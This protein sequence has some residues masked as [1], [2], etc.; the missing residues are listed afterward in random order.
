MQRDL[1]NI[2][3]LDEET[4]GL[5]YKGQQLITL[6]K[7]DSDVGDDY[8]GTLD[9]DVSQLKDTMRTLSFMASKLKP[10]LIELEIPDT[11]V[12]EYQPYICEQIYQTGTTDYFRAGFVPS[13]YDDNDVL[14]FSTLIT[15]IRD[16]KITPQLRKDFEKFCEIT[17]LR[18]YS[19]NAR[20][21]NAMAQVSSFHPITL[22]DGKLLLFPSKRA[23]TPMVQLRQRPFKVYQ[24]PVNKEGR[25]ITLQDG[26]SLIPIS[27]YS[28][29]MHKGMFHGTDILGE[30]AEKYNLYCGTFYYWEPESEVYLSV[31]K[32][33]M[34]YAV[35][36]IGAAYQLLQ[37]KDQTSTEVVEEL[38]QELKNSAHSY[39]WEVINF[40]IKNY[41]KRR[42]VTDADIEQ[43]I[44]YS[45]D[46]P[47]TLPLT[48]DL[49]NPK[50]GEYVNEVYAV[51]D[52]LDQPLCIA[53][54]ELGYDVIVL[55]RCA[56]LR[57]TVTEILDTR[58]R[59]DSLK[60]LAWT[61]A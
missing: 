35:N 55:G 30:E 44:K 15:E 54:K 12:F 24:G 29:G 47:N 22:G 17:E 57:R 50:T 49:R 32:D 16:K 11:K 27:R 26:T 39:V 5:F 4:I 46:E 7:I 1:F 21:N 25:I 28:E 14:N 36:K 52:E 41:R 19:A 2:Q 9:V 42:P 23:R 56:G 33:R 34:F 31:K 8:I 18:W 10:D 6:E 45:L 61:V 38:E 20:I 37:H 51:D 58:S 40:G 48:E 59:S 13:S 3:Q 60:S 43:L 53:A